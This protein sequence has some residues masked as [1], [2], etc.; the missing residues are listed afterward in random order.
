VLTVTRTGGGLQVAAG[1]EV[2][3]VDDP[4]AVRCDDTT[5][6]PNVAFARCDYATTVETL[7]FAAGE[8]S[9]TVSI[10][11]VNDA[12]VEPNE[13]VQV[14]LSSVAGNAVLGAQT[15]FTLTI[16]SDDAAGAA[17]PLDGP[18]H[19]FFV[20]QQY[21]D[22]LSREPEASG[23]AAWLG[24]LNNCANPYNHDPAAPAAAC[25]R[26]LVSSSFF[27]SAEFEIK[28]L[29]VFRLYRV[30]FGR[31]PLYSEIIPDM[32]AVTGQTAGE[33]FQK[34]AA[35]A[36]QLAART[37]FQA[38]HAQLNNAQ[39]VSALMG[40]YGLASITTPD[41]AAPDGA[42]KVTLSSAD[43]AARLDAGTLTRGRV[44]RAVAD[45]D[46]V[47]LAERDRAFVAMQYFGYLRRNPDQGGFQSWLNYLA[48]NPGDYYTMVNG[49]L[50]SAE[51]RLRFGRE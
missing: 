13:T 43:L 10:P 9:K 15:T 8:G 7:N 49:F 35:F 31:L 22:F 34:K 41:P 1:V 4:A 6:R 17:N 36:E 27:R 24:V 16:V 25:D 37:E 26:N 12:H 28:G 42:A 47:G 20:R 5:T 11:L 29:Y 44:L 48:A 45:S 39:F 40:R 14:V 46:Q 18:P 3:T 2:R 51:Y 33:V 50:Y 23:M 19:E 21:L 38:A 30:A 32:R